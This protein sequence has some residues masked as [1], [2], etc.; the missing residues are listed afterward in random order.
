MNN[1]LGK[2]IIGGRT[3]LINQEVSLEQQEKVINNIIDAYSSISNNWEYYNE[4]ELEDIL[5]GKHE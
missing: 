1:P 5:K 2:L 3:H 4:V